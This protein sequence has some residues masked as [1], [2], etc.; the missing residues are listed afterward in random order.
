MERFGWSLV[1]TI[2]IGFT[3][4]HKLDTHPF[5]NKKGPVKMQ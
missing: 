3:S 4:F 2:N 5:K 1:P